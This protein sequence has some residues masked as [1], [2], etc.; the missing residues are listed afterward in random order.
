VAAPDDPVELRGQ[1]TRPGFAPPRHDR[2]PDAHDLTVAVG[3]EQLRE[4]AGL[5]PSVV[6]EERDDLA[7]RAPVPLV[8]SPFGPPLATTV[9]A[10]YACE[11]REK[12][13]GLWSMTR[14]ISSGG[15]CWRR[16]DSMA[17]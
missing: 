17:S 4:P 7:A 5:C 6:V 14:M 15:Y 11:A 1:P 12:S 16:T 8:A 13:A 3:L 10:G 2:P 9:I